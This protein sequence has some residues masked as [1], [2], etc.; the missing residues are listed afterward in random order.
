[1][2]NVPLLKRRSS[3]YRMRSRTSC[4]MWR[5]QM[6]PARPLI[7]SKG[8]LTRWPSLLTLSVFYLIFLSPCVCW[9]FTA[10][11]VLSEWKQKYEETQAELEASQKE[12]RSLSTELFK[13]KNAYEESLDQLETIKR[14]NKN[15]QRESSWT[16]LPHTALH[17]PSH[18]AIS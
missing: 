15:L 16:S 13:V 6:L 18:V 17:G 11:Q 12:S 2:R 10:F 3:G 14:E 7:R 5:E 1:M 4:L 9:W 8:T